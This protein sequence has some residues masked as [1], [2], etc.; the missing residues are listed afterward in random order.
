MRHGAQRFFMTFPPA[1]S[2]AY[3]DAG[4]KTQDVRS[5]DFYAPALEGR[6]RKGGGISTAPPRK[7]C[8]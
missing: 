5:K 2:I 7:G 1:G 4:G 6:S 3:A 8:L